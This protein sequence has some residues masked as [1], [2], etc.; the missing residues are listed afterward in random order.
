LNNTRSAKKRI[1]I[2]S[3]NPDNRPDQLYNTL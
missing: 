3:Q 2:R 1:I